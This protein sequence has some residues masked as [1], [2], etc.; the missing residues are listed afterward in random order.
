MWKGKLEKERGPNRMQEVKREKQKQNIFMK[1]AGHDYGS[2][3]E[4]NPG[5][6]RKD[7][8]HEIILQ[9]FGHARCH[10]NTHHA[11]S[12]CMKFRHRDSNPG[13][14]GEGRVS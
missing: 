13:R 10:S 3:W 6:K 14:S 9:S 2:N 1:L 4:N 12:H 11:S 8:H 7:K 5:S